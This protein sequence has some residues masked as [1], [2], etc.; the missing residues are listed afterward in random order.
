[1]DAFLP[2]TRKVDRQL[3]VLLDIPLGPDDE[4][5]V[6]D[7]LGPPRFADLMVAVGPILVVGFGL[8]LGCRAAVAEER[9]E[10]VGEDRGDGTCRLPHRG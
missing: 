7:K 5:I 10:A 8:G 2:A 9:G 3:L 6:A 4:L 1:M